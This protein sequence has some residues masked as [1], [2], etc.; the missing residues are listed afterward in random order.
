MSP[1]TENGSKPKKIII[2]NL[3]MPFEIGKLI[4]YLESS[5]DIKP[6]DTVVQ[7][8]SVIIEL[9]QSDCDVV[10]SDKDSL[11]FQKKRV[12]YSGLS[13]IKIF[14]FLQF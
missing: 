14:F 4:G 1:E 7:Q 12:I 3:P 5:L 6:I 9:S 8:N 2:E 10:M 13:N 11:I